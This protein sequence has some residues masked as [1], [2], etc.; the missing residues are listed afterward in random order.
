VI[1]YV[2][3]NFLV[4]L[5]R[6][7][8]QESAAELILRHAEA[9]RI[10]FALP[11]SSFSEPMSALDRHASDRNRFVDNLDAQATE[12]GRLQPHKTL[13]SALKRVRQVF[14][15]LK[16]TEMDRLAGITL[17]TLGVADAILLTPSL[18]A[19]ARQCQA[20]FEL[21]LQDSIV[22]ASIFYHASNQ[23]PDLVKCFISRDAKAFNDP[24]LKA[25]LSSVNCRYISNFV[26]GLRYI[27]STLVSS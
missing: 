18:F 19:Q 12:L 7:Q 2:E 27:E 6:R 10:H 8:E 17:R 20:R 11:S 5:A 24:D 26:D 3:A 1:V 13:A 23:P 9:R 4:E 21:S 14:I 16:G 25:A 15:S 22:F